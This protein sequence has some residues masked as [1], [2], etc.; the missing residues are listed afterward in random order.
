MDGPAKSRAFSPVRR[1]S[2]GSSGRG[3]AN[4]YGIVRQLG[5]QIY[6]ESEPGDGARFEIWFPRVT[7]SA[8]LRSAPGATAR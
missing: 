6:L 4:A 1:S 7:S 8:Q 3:L 2:G 5:G